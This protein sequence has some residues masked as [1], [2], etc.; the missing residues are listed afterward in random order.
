MLYTTHYQKLASLLDIQLK[1]PLLPNTRTFPA[2]DCRMPHVPVNKL[3]LQSFLRCFGSM[4]LLS[5]LPLLTLSLFSLFLAFCIIFGFT[6]VHENAYRT[7]TRALVRTARHKHF[8]FTRQTLQSFDSSCVHFGCAFGPL[9]WLPVGQKILCKV[10]CT[11]TTC[12][13]S[14][15]S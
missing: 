3:L 1:G 11:P 6:I 10:C 5:L 2:S 13:K 8:T 9:L 15:H 14:L 4:L 12:N 7:Y